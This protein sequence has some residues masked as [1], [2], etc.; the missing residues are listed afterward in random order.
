MVK[1]R[2]E[3]NKDYWKKLKEN[4]EQ[5]EDIKRRNKF[6]AAK[7]FIRIHANDKELREL[8]LLINDRLKPW[9]VIN[10]KREKH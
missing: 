1:S 2:S 3:I 10:T 5:Y 8:H 9:S 4:P 6:A 7:S